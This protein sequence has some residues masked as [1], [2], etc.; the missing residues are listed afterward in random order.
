MSSNS[1]EEFLPYLADFLMRRNESIVTQVRRMM[2]RGRDEARSIDHVR[3]IDGE[4]EQEDIVVARKSRPLKRRI[5]SPTP[6]EL[7]ESIL[8]EHD[9]GLEDKLDD[10][11][12]EQLLI[13]RDTA[14]VVLEH[15]SRKKDEARLRRVAIEIKG[16]E[17]TTMWN[18]EKLLLSD[19]L[20]KRLS[21]SRCRSSFRVPFSKALK[22]EKF[23][24]CEA[25]F[26]ETNTK[27]AYFKSQNYYS[28]F[29]YLKSDTDLMEQVLVQT[30]HV[31]ERFHID[32]GS[33]GIFRVKEEPAD[34]Q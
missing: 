31:L 15:K 14:P 4:I 27:T 18:Q 2:D 5:E 29:A 3:N 11:L 6:R 28:G 21:C 9:E 1:L 23:K 12:L 33:V 26:E 10:V 20:M 32:H 24:Q 34:S 16:K 17:L 25:I 19:F 22:R 30:T 7:A 13:T 8:Q